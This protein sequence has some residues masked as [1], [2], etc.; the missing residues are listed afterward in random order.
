MDR[1]TEEENRAN[2]AT[3]SLQRGLESHVFAM[4]PEAAVGF[5]LSL[6]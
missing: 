1:G 2:S 6:E 4:T 5:E 3:S